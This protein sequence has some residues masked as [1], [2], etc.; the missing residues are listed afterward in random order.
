MDSRVVLRSQSSFR[1]ACN[2]SFA[3]RRTAAFP[4][5]ISRNHCFNRSRSIRIVFISVFIRRP[6]L[7][8][9]LKRIPLPSARPFAP[10]A[11]RMWAGLRF[12]NGYSPIRPA[13]VAREFATYIHGEIDPNMGEWLVWNEAGKDGAARSTWH[14]WDNHRKRIR[15][16]CRGRRKNGNGLSRTTKRV[17]T[18]DG[19]VRFRVV[20]SI[21]WDGNTLLA[22]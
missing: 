14:R 6:S 15:L 13:G 10:A 18:I 3:F 7:P 8:I 1:V 21:H 19:A 11:L 5:T 17:F 2:L 22:E 9:A 4:N 12:V 16:H 20:R